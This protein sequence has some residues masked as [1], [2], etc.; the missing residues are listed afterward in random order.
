MTETSAQAGGAKKCGKKSLL[1][2]Q[3]A[4][5]GITKV[6]KINKTTEIELNSRNIVNFVTDTLYTKKVS[7]KESKYKESA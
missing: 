3:N 6:L 7:N 5:R 1:N 2:A 4:N